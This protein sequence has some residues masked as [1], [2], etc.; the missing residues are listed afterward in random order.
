[1]RHIG[2]V[3]LIAVSAAAVGLLSG[4]AQATPDSKVT[5]TVLAQGSTPD[6]VRVGTDGPTE[7]VI[8]QITIAPGGS[9]GWHYHS[10]TLLAIVHK[11]M[12][13]RTDS[14]CRS[15]SYSAGQS[16]VEPSGSGEIHVGRNLGTEPV[17]LYVTYVDPARSP[18]S[19]DASDPGCNI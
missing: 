11:G 16:L 6:H 12:L 13:T 10:G 19:I 15:V 14:H 18:L 8:R 3:A 9:T 4:A 5:G 1:M 7:F 17:E 2:K